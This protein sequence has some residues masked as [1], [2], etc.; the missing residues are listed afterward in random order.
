MTT[1]PA[2]RLW[3]QLELLHA[4]TYFAPQSATAMTDLGLK[5]FWMGYF[6][7]RAAVFG[8][9][10]PAV[11]EATFYN[12]DPSL[13]RRAVPDAWSRTTPEAVLEAR[14]AAA[15]QVLRDAVPGIDEAASRIVPL[16]SSA[17]RSG[18]PDGRA[19]FASNQV[20]E[21]SDD[22]VAALWQCATALREHRGDGHVAALVAADLSGVEA[23]QIVVGAGLISDDVLRSVRGYDEDSWAA[24]KERLRT[25]GL[26]DD[27]GRLTAKG[28]GE[29]NRIEALTDELALQPYV[30]GLTEPGLDLLPSLLRPL[31]SAVAAAGI[32][33]FPNPIGV[34]RDD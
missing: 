14:A 25:R 9:C 29:R 27:D 34:E 20:L 17:V 15:A 28:D 5:G 11:V 18:R 4:V 31:A 19:L 33:P 10:G 12:F 3:R 32:V 24:A 7:G 30:D 13:V 22:P 26:L 1:N 2:R 6:A 16:L 8:A 21:L 23:H